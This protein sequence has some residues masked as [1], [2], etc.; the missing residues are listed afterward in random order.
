MSILTHSVNRWR[1]SLFVGGVVL[2]AAACTE[3][4]R[5]D[6]AKPAPSLQ[7]EARVELSD[8]LAAPGTEVDVTV[9]VVGARLASM[10]ARLAYDS[11]GMHFVRE[12]SV[13]DGATRVANPQPGLVRFAAIAPNGFADGRVYTLR[14]SV[15]RSSALRSFQLSTDEAHSVS[16]ANLVP[17][18]TRKP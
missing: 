13:S 8:S 7:P 15:V 4:R 6:Q 1:A 9:R 11:S 2:A 5:T 10:T 14:F 17:A 3:P 12:E 16:Q 18:L